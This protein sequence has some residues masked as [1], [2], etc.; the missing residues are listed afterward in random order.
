MKT[1]NNN[2]NIG[3]DAVTIISTGVVLEGKIKSNGNLRIDGVVN[4]NIHAEGN[5]TVGEHGEINGEIQANII[6]LGGKIVGTVAANEK[7]VLESTSNLKGDI[8]T[9][10]LVVEEGAIFDG[11]SKMGT[12]NNTANSSVPEQL[13]K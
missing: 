3:Q 2:S 4:G 5:L 13:K 8:I 6:I 10:I 12:K 7:M 11:N 1:R 9:K